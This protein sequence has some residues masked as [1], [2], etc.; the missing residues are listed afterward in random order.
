[1]PYI[2]SYFQRG[3]RRVDLVF[4]HYK[5]GSLKG[6]VRQSRGTGRAVKVDIETKRPG[7]WAAFLRV[8]SNKT[9]LFELISDYL[10]CNMIIPE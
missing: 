2:C 5:K 3:Y 4:D 10:I 6:E 9:N 1:M 8:D 7:D